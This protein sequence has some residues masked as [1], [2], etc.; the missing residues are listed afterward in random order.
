MLY[1]VNRVVLVGR[2]TSDPNV[3]M[4]GQTS[5]CVFSLAVNRPKG[6][7]GK[8]NGVDFLRVISFAS[9]ADKAM[10]LSKGQ[11]VVV[12]GKVNTGSYEK[13]GQKVYTTDFVAD[14]IGTVI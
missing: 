5:K 13:N 11:S 6:K 7:D 2:L 9:L 14:C 8:E 3:M 1:D 10:E 12:I 4:A